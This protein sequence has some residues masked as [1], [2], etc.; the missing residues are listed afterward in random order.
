[1]QHSAF[2]IEGFKRL[3]LVVVDLKAFENSLGL[4]V[5]PDGKF[6]SAGVAFSFGFGCLI[7]RV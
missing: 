2:L 3:G 4:V 6:G 1:M 5:C 7:Y